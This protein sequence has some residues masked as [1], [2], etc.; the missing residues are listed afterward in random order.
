MAALKSIRACLMYGVQLG[1]QGFVSISVVALS[2]PSEFDIVLIDA[3]G[4]AISPLVHLYT[5]VRVSTR[6]G[7]VR[8][9]PRQLVEHCPI[10]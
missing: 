9:F 8:F 2:V 4:D 6:F 7:V 3:A 1:I 5:S 10:N